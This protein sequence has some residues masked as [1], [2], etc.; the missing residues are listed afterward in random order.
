MPHSIE[1]EQ[2]VLGGLMLDNQRFDQVSEILSETDFYRES[3]SQIFLMMARLAEDG[4]PL[5]VITLSEELHRND[6]LER[7][8]G[9]S[10]LSEMASHTPSATNISAYAR[11]VRERS[12]LRQ[13][14][15]AANEISRSSQNPAGLDSDDLLQMAER[16][17]AQIAEERPKDGGFLDANSLLKISVEKIDQRFRSGSDLT[18]LSSGLTDLDERT[19]GWQPGELIILAARPSMGKTALALN[20]VEAA[21]MTQSK[22]ALVFSMEMP[23]DALVMRMLS[24]LGRIEANK[25][26]NGSLTEE[27]WPKLSTAV[28]KLKDKPLYIDDT[29]GL[30]PQEVR[31]RVKRVTRTHLM[32]LQQKNPELTQ[33]EL[34][35]RSRPGMIMLDYLQLMQV[36]GRSEGRTQEI[37][38]I[39]RSLKALAKEYSCPV[40]ALS[41]LNRGVEQRPNKR[42]MNSDLR[43]SG[44]IE[45]DADVILFIYRDEYYNEES[46]D[47]GVAE[48]IVGK[49]RNGEVG[50][51]KAAFVGKFTRF[52]NLAPEYYNQMDD[53]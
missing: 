7:V 1:A 5:D 30:T 11:I 29:P 4:Q 13:L 32:E 41:Q 48:L 3:H 39:S 10:Y 47:K 50:T 25:L 31:A 6:L 36:S 20:F 22:P 49:Q 51:S 21:I 44:A 38:E 24:S 37:S 34:E 33:E 17:V 14:I 9:L 18:G 12:T 26:R 45:Q 42:P 23:A 16:R 2:A 8:G 27:D 46:Q 19:S 53:F 52:E 43:E 40:I 15:H 35:E 28:A